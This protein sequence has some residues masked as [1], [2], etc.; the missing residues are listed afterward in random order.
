VKGKD[1]QKGC[2][3]VNLVEILYT[4]VCKWKRPFE[5]IP[6]IGERGIKE[7]IAEVNSAMI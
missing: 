4:C 2:R 3:M 7:N 6:E 1:I 5:T